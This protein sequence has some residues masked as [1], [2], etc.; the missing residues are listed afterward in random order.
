VDC[1][2]GAEIAVEIRAERSSP[3]VGPGT[4]CHGSVGN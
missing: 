3:R 4:N 1:K 2:G